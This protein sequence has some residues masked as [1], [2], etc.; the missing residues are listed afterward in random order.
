MYEILTI[1]PSEILIIGISAGMTAG[2]V[3][4]LLSF[5]ISV[6]KRVTSDCSN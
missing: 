6:F 4:K 5:I 1:N 2:I 3:V